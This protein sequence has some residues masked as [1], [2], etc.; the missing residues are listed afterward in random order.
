M[1]HQ[2]A[3]PDWVDADHSADTDDE[4]HSHVGEEAPQHAHGQTSPGAIALFGLASFAALLVTLF[5]LALFF[6]RVT[7]GERVEKIERVDL[8]GS[9]FVQRKA[10]WNAEL[11]GYGWADPERVSIPIDQA[12]ESVAREY[13]RP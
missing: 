4:W 1:T 3:D 7:L 8:L 13:T 11:S 12:I 9:D 5:V 10:G 6:N 2:P